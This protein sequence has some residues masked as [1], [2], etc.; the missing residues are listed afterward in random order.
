MEKE[1]NEN[2]DSNQ[3]D[4]ESSSYEGV[5]QDSEGNFIFI[6]EDDKFLRD[7]LLRK[8]EDKGHKVEV[9]ISGVKAFDKIKEAQ[10][11]IVLLDLVLP[12][13]SGYDVLKQLK[14]DAEVKDIPVIILSNLGQ[15]EEVE[16]G[17]ELGAEDYMIKAHF[18]PDEIIE[19]IKSII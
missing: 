13:G 19:K 16:K 4:V 11:D 12:E 1:N 6:V 8:L 5:K 2:L 15:K 18:T 9:A 3:Q 14:D 7:L 17:L 10:P